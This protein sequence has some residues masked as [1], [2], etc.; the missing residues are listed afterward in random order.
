MGARVG[1]GRAARAL[2]GEGS[3]GQEGTRGVLLLLGGTQGW[4]A[5]M[6]EAVQ[7]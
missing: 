3:E 6:Q 7:G 2:H 4:G 5:G 1:A